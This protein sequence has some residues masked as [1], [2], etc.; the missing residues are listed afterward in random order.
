MFLLAEHPAVS[1][2]LQ[3][4][5][6][7]IQYVPIVLGLL[8]LMV[9]DIITRYCAAVSTDTVCMHD[10]FKATNRKIGTLLAIG[11]GAVVETMVPDFPV[12]KGISMFYSGFELLSISTNLKACGI[13]IW[14][15]WSDMIPKF[16]P[17][18]KPVD[19]TTTIVQTPAPPAVIVNPDPSPNP[20]TVTTHTETTVDT[21][22]DP[23]PEVT[24]V[25]AEEEHKPKPDSHKPKKPH[26]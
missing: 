8:V 4:V 16:A 7:Y 26:H 15:G 20:T 5:F 14:G 9:I 10:I 24:P 13:P 11:A 19:T 2:E 22:N 18:P 3:V 6:H 1:P 17:D 25:V 21:H 12:T 23:P